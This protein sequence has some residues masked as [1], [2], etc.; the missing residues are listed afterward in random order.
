MVNVTAYGEAV[1]IATATAPGRDVLDSPEAIWSWNATAPG[2][3]RALHRAASQVARRRH[4]RFTMVAASWEYQ[5]RGA[6]HRHVVLGLGTARELAAAHTY[7]R[8]LHDLRGQFG[9]GFIDRGRRRG[10][11]RQLE[12]I[13]PTRAAR[14]LAKYLAPIDRET[15][16]LVLSATV[17][18]PDVPAIVVYVSRA[19]T[20]RTNCTMRELRRVRWLHVQA[21]RL[22]ITTEDVDE[23]VRQGA[24]VNALLP[25]IR[26]P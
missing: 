17:T 3:W 12:V 13:P 18:K 23:L 10:G 7:V 2:R 16:K 25:A 19:L 4:G 20:M 9:F 24:D 26:G 22:D 14:Y 6:L 8:A 5:R 21:R 11:R 15:G 1:A